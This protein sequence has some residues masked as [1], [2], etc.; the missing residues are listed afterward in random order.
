VTSELIITFPTKRSKDA[1]LNSIFIGIVSEKIGGTIVGRLEGA[2]NAAMQ[3]KNKQQTTKENILF[4][5][6]SPPMKIKVMVSLV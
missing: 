6:P 3:P 2:P 4:S 1:A 5:C